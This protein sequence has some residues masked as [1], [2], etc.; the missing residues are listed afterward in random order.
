M[1]RLDDLKLDI[2]DKGS[3]NQKFE[4]AF[5]RLSI[6]FYVMGADLI[7]FQ[8]RPWAPVQGIC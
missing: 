4:I 2:A 8:N 6:A 7:V 1:N 3:G 5:Y